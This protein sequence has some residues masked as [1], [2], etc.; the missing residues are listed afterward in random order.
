MM[1]VAATTATVTMTMD[2][3]GDSVGGN[4]DSDSNGRDSDVGDSNDDNCG[5]ATAK[6]ASAYNNH[7]KRQQKKWL[8]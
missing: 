3:K 5:A 2:C 4:Y 8:W 6:V 1:T 7:S